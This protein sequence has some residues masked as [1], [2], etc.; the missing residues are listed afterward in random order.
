MILTKRNDLERFIRE[1][2]IGHG[3]M[4]CRYVDIQNP[5]LISENLREKAPLDYINEIINNAPGAMYSTGILFPVDA[6]RT[7]IV[8]TD[9][10]TDSADEESDVVGSQE[11]ITDNDISEVESLSVNQMYPIVMGLTCCLDQRLKNI[12]E[13]SIKI[14]ARY[15]EKIKR[16]EI[17]DRYGLLLEQ[18]INVFKLFINSLDAD[19]PI[20]QN[21]IIHEFEKNTILTFSS[22]KVEEIGYFKS[23]LREIDRLKTQELGSDKE[24]QY[25]SGYKEYLF[26]ELRYNTIDE[27]EQIRLATKI[28]DIEAIECCIAHLNDLISIFDSQ[29][30]GLWKCELLERDIKIP[31]LLPANFKNKVVFSYK[32]YQKLKDIIKIDLG[33][34]DYASLSV[35]LQIS[36]G[37]RKENTSLYLKVQ[38]VNTSTEFVLSEA[39]SRYYSVFNEVVNQRSFFG[40]KVTL[41]KYRVSS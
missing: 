11:N 5:E 39:D 31:E 6:S 23:R 3:V 8:E 18:D 17:V 37:S 15:Y 1:Q 35:N 41:D 19:D 12:E 32:K 29:G 14:Q 4:G 16:A 26:R 7:A 36:K 34:N 9:P 22:I 25:L 20:K 13:V 2:T 40:T 24:G 30:Y 33:S 38:L 21:L 27:N 28:K 10:D